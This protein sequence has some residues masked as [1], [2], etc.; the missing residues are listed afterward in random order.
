MPLDQKDIDALRERLD[1]LH[2]EAD[3][4][5]ALLAKAFPEPVLLLGHKTLWDLVPAEQRVTSEKIP[6]DS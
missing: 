6:L 4:Y 3:Q 1:Q 5:F 2:R